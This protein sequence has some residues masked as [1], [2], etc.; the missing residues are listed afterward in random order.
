M[1]EEKLRKFKKIIKKSLSVLLAMLMAITMFNFDIGQAH[2]YNAGEN[3]TITNFDYIQTNDGGNT[4]TRVKIEGSKFIQ[5]FGP[6]DGNVDMRTVIKDITVRSGAETESLMQGEAVRAGVKVEI[7]D[8]I[9]TITAPKTGKFSTLNINTNSS[10]TISIDT[11]GTMSKRKYSFDVQVNG[12]PSMPGPLKNKKN[13]VGEPLEIIGDNFN[14]VTDVVIA[15]ASHKGSDLVINPDGEKIN[16]PSLNKNNLNESERIQFIKEDNKSVNTDPKPKIQFTVEYLDKVLVF[17]KLKGMDNLRVLPSEGYY[18]GGNKITVQALNKEGDEILHNIFSAGYNIILRREVQDGTST[19]EQTIKLQDVK[20]VYEVPDDETSDIVAIE[21]WVPKGNHPA[22]TTW[23]VVIKDPG[24][25]SSEGIARQAYTLITSNPAPQIEGISPSGGPNTGGTD[26][27][28]TGRNFLTVNTPGLTIPTATKILPDGEATVEN[29]T[30]LNINY[31]NIDGVEFGKQ[32]VTD[33]QRKMK[34]RISTLTNANAGEIYANLDRAPKPGEEIDG[35][36][37]GKFHFMVKDGA[38]DGVVFTTTSAATAGQETVIMDIETILTLADGTTITIPEAAKYSPFIFTEKN[39]TPSINEVELEYGFFNDSEEEEAPPEG[40]DDGVKPLML[41]IKGEKFEVIKED[42]GKMTFPTVQF[43]LP[44]NTV[45]PAVSSI[46]P[47]DTKV[48]DEKGNPIDGIYTKTGTT[49]VVSIIPPSTDKTGLRAML[50]ATLEQAGNY[51]ILDGIVQV[52]NPSGNSNTAEETGAKFQFR[53]PTEQSLTETHSKQPVITS[54]VRNGAPVK[55][56]PSDAETEI[57]I[58]LK[59]VAGISDLTKLKVTVDGLD[60]SNRIKETKLEGEEAVINVTVPK[61]FVGKSRIQVIIPEGLMDSYQ[62]IFDNVRGP[63]IKELIPSEGDKG[64]IVVIK[65]DDQ[66]NEVSF[67]TPI[68][69]SK[70]EQER[71]GSKVLWNGKDINEV[72]NGYKKDGSGNVAYQ[73]SEW[74]REFKQTDK[75]KEPPFVDVPGKYVYVVDSDT[76]YLKIPDDELLKEGTYK[77]QIK[78]PDGAESSVGADFTVID[79]IDKTI[80]GSIVPEKDDVNGGIIVK[81]T[82][83]ENT[84]FKGEVDVWFGSNKAEVIGYDLEYKELYAKV[85]PLVDFKFP[86]TLEDKVE[87]FT[88]PVTVQNKVNKS[89]DTK[90]NGFTYLNPTYKMKITQ[91]YNEKYSTDPTRKDAATGVEGDTLVIR[92]E[93]FRVQYAE[94]DRVDKKNPI[95][96]SVMF[97]YELAEPPIEFGTKNPGPDGKPI[98]DDKGRAELEWVKVKV[99]KRPYLG[100]GSNGEV[101]LLVQNPDGA[102]AIKEKGFQYISSK[103]EIIEASSVLQASRFFDTITVDV[104]DINPNGVLVAFGKKIYEKELAAS[105]MEIETTEEVEKLVFKYTPG[106]G[107]NIEVFYRKPDGTLLPMTDAEGTNNG[108]FRLADI[109]DT[110]VIGI[111]WRNPEYHSTGITKNPDLINNLNKEYVLL[112]AKNKAPNINALVIRRGFGKVTNAVLDSKTNIT[113][114]TIDTPYWEKIENTT[115]TVINQ[116]GSSD[117]APF[118]FHGGLEGPVITDIDGSKTRDLTIDGKHVESKVYTTDYTEEDEITIIGKNFKNVEKVTIGQYTVEV[119]NISQDYTKMR[120][121]V[122]QGK[123]ED[124]GKPL[125][126]VIITEEGNAISS[127]STPPVYYMFIQA[128]SKPEITKVEPN[129]GPQ[130]GGT[131]I[132]IDGKNFSEMDEF[133]VKGEIEVMIGGKKA[134]VERTITNEH[135]EIIALEVIAPPVEMIE[136]MATLQV[137]NADGGRGTPAEFKYI[138]QPLIEKIDGTI[139]FNAEEHPDG[140]QVK[141]RVFGKNFYDPQY[142]VIGGEVEQI[143]KNLDKEDGSLMRGVKADGSNQYLK[144]AENEDGTLKG[145]KLEVIPPQE[146][147]VDEKVDKAW[148]YFDVVIPIITPEE[149]DNIKTSDIIVV[150]DDGGTSSEAPVDIKMP[151]PKAPAIIATPGFNNT[152]NLTW[153]LKKDDLN[154]ADRFEVYIKKAGVG[155]DYVHVGDVA[156]N[157]DGSLDYSYLIKNTEP[158]TDYQIKVRVMNKYGEAEDF[159]YANITTLAREDDY[160]LKEKDKE[161]KRSQDNIRQNGTKKVVG[162]K[163]IYTVGTLEN[164]IPLAGYPKVTEKVVRIPV[165]QIKLAPATNI[166]ISDTDMTLVVPFEAFNLPQVQQVS[167]DSVVQISII[168]TDG[169]SD[170]KVSGLAKKTRNNRLSRVHNIKVDLVEPKRKTAIVSTKKPMTLTLY[171]NKQNLGKLALYDPNTNRLIRNINPNI[172]KGGYYVQISN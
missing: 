64:T 47:D 43:V 15:G 5:N 128:G 100:I 171:S 53:R 55:K 151:I 107:D 89:S 46:A 67:K 20:V 14:G 75:D 26:V 162:N 59:A 37:F 57:E 35:K 41:R 140:D 38:T 8:S 164:N 95:L 16:I 19:K 33:I 153:H 27:L 24:N 72:F 94:D 124:V 71:I 34:V 50:N 143:D 77:L 40:G 134:R 85:P 10:T 112:E 2:A 148:P 104:R 9:I 146:G 150:D 11:D 70:N 39:P 87:K 73:K 65:R 90:N 6:V 169:K 18:K 97:G 166:K 29:N 142:V 74:F 131:K 106:P 56:L 141:I 144:F 149:M 52:T 44:D 42:D 118:K 121:R 58:R 3:I 96:P 111:N 165:A 62:I 54:I 119:L 117:D 17:E 30:I 126:V 145:K 45:I 78:N 157:Q 147:T 22:N 93:N 66:A 159:G 113:K 68:E 105:A 98:L 23:D 133:G 137:K 91:V 49:L 4:S 48:L 21:G 122:P 120:V 1:R 51:K 123:L 13:Y 170:Q 161:L 79:S 129:K 116:D 115:I 102:K 138:S 109:G 114:L 136:D 80:I 76:I 155:F 156:K 154:K 12:L 32:E 135:G 101:D 82:A 36:P 125:P 163:L 99:P 160:K 172:N 158:N 7:T 88:V 31:K 139:Q 167:D 152:I 83:G 110:K 130:T 108:K 92:G 84:N 168:N 63:E 86:S 81:I 69:N 127:E 25:V 60:I 132:R 28:I 103:P 61:G